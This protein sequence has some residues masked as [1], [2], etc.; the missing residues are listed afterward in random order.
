MRI[1]H[2]LDF[3][4]LLLKLKKP[5]NKV[6]AQMLDIVINESAALTPGAKLSGP[7]VDNC[8]LAAELVLSAD[9]I[10]GVLE[11]LTVLTLLGVRL[12]DSTLK[13]IA[14]AL[15][16]L[17]NDATA[18]AAGLLGRHPCSDWISTL[19][20]KWL[21]IEREVRVDPEQPLP[22]SLNPLLNAA[23]NAVAVALG[24]C[25]AGDTQYKSFARDIKLSK[26]NQDVIEE[27][28][29]NV[30]EHNDLVKQYRN[31][32]LDRAQRITIETR[33]KSLQ[34]QLDRQRHQF[35]QQGRKEYSPGY[36]LLQC[37]RGTNIYPVS[38]RQGAAWG[39]HLLRT[40]GQLTEKTRNELFAA[41]REANDVEGDRQFCER[42]IQ[43]LPGRGVFELTETL[44]NGLQWMTDLV[45]GEYNGAADQSQKE[46]QA[47]D[48]PR[49][50][51]IVSLMCEI[52]PGA[53]DF[54]QAHP[55]RLMPLDYHK[56]LL[57]Q[58]LSTGGSLVYWT[59]YTPPKNTG[60]VHMRYLS[61]EDRST[62]N[63]MG[64]YYKLFRHPILALPVIYHEF[65]HYG[66]PAGDPLQGIA[67]ETD[68][69]LREL[70]FARYLIAWL[71]PANDDELPTFEESLLSE[72]K[73][74]EI[75]SLFWQLSYDFWDDAVL[76][77]INT[78][79]IEIYGDQMSENQVEWRWAQQ[80][81]V[82]NL[83]IELQNKL[84]TWAPEIT[85][86]TLGSARTHEATERYREM[87]RRR[88]MCWHR[89][90]GDERNR[91]L[92]TEPCVLHTRAWEQYLSRKYAG[93]H[94]L[95]APLT[96]LEFANHV[97]RLI[98]RRFDLTQRGEG[99]LNE[100]SGEDATQERSLI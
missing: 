7:N 74:A 38:A 13:R 69:L 81:L 80:M 22:D 16:K 67:N 43:L 14:E 87:L 48:F 71:A 64:I 37:L 83:G 93:Q 44:R 97:L 66:G 33:L 94:L 72:I 84:L 32:N 82:E 100:G 5:I 17:S 34:P 11:L 92:N 73:H 41:L 61:V 75:D 54:F 91:I 68:V 58:F 51:E 98:V 10:E 55:L 70:S 9:Q 1:R 21:S 40:R 85:W 3:L 59:R 36:L 30:S 76:A 57:G 6:L 39:L 99:D 62:P 8:L 28:N 23:A 90:N 35:D 79:V 89:I 49:L 88:W 19:K 56:K 18:R 53:L 4:R 26:K 86:P 25:A 12:N 46:A 65:M 60:P 63:S 29:K 27:Y 20:H 50:K 47:E 15:P 45:E 52:L 42:H 24:I 31:P 78:E 2:T 96:D 77:D 95:P